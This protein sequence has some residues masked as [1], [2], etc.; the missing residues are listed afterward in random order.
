VT[1][2]TFLLAG[3]SEVTVVDYQ[4]VARFAAGFLGFTSGR[5]SLFSVERFYFL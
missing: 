3:S 1:V 4:D 2:I 5:E